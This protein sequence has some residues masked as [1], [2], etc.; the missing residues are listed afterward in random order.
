MNNLK[1]WIA[2][3]LM[4]FAFK[5]RDFLRPRRVILAE[6]GIKRGDY[7]LDYGCGPGRYIIPVI[8]LIGECGMLYAVDSNIFAIKRVQNIALKKQLKNLV[9]IHSDCETGLKDDI[10]D[11]ILLYD[12]LHLLNFPE[13]VLDELHRILKRDGIL[14]VT[15]H[16]MK[17]EKIVSRITG[18]GLFRLEKSGRITYSFK[19]L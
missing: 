11:V 9:A 10:I 15:D 13:K 7:V 5:I 12:V 16:H 6:T 19:K 3:Q 4:D 8:E 14:S 18:N 2:F 1:T 17:E